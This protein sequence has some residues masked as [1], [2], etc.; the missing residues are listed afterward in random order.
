MTTT[1]HPS[2]TAFLAQGHVPLVIGGRREEAASG[3]TIETRNPATGELIATVP[4]G[5]A[6]DVD[7]AV[8]AARAALAGEWASWKPFERQEL[9]LRFAAL[10]EERFDELTE[11]ETIDMGSP[12]FRTRAGRRRV[13]G[14]LRYY[15]GLATTLD[16]RTVEN[17]LLGGDFLTYTVKE[18]VGV[19]GAIIAWNSPLGATTW[20]LGPVLATGC[21][22]VLK[23]AEQAPL[24]PLRLAELLAEAG[25][26]DGVV[27]VVTGYGHDAGAALAA[28]PGVD[29]IA[30][31][32]SHLTGQKIIEASAGNLKRVSLELGG[33]SPDIVFADADLD[34]AVPGA[35]LA[36]FMNS[37]QNCSAGT[38][39]FVQRGIYDEFVQRVGA[40]A[41]ELPVGDPLDLEVK[42][43]PVVSGE[44][45]DRVLG[46]IET[47]AREGAEVVAGG[48]RL[49]GGAFDRGHFVAPTIFGGVSDEMTIAREAIFGPVI[50][51]H[52]IDDVDEV[53]ERSNASHFG[54]A[55]GVWTRD[56]GTAHRVARGLQAGSVWVNCYH[57]M[58]VAM[59]FGGYKMSGYG[60]E[61]GIEQLEEYLNVKA[62]CIQTD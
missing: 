37:G 56:L 53:I 7:R 4:E 54:L 13:I 43:G 55:S 48:T 17:S 6:P 27:N 15:A 16:G 5:G 62:V 61:S 33:K 47:G 20:K 45:L 9:L 21:T 14:L 50:S 51:A 28:H 30:F 22:L 19:V 25:L 40:F 46:Y 1:A 42:I 32:G 34:K 2:E 58:D 24:I 10:V 26:P 39:L 11:L 52:A 31:T 29:K 44:Q 12:L 59:P 3:R 35:A 36:T 49:E 60:R 18:P 38:R 57:A 41:R 8:A 23:P